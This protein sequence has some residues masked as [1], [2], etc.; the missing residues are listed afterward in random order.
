MK[1]EET[2]SLYFGARSSD[3]PVSGSLNIIGVEYDGAASFRKGA[4]QGPEAIRL[5]SDQL[6]SYSP[7]LD[8]DLG[9][10]PSYYDLG[11]LSLT[12]GG[13]ADQEYKA[14]RDSFA[15]LAGELDLQQ[16]KIRFLALGGDHSIAYPFIKKYLQ[17]YPYLLLIHLDAHAD[18]RDGFEGNFYSHASTMR[19]CLDHFGPRHQLVQFGIRSGTREEFSWMRKEKTLVTDYRQ[20]I[21]YLQE[22]PKGQPIYLTIDLDFFDPAVLPGTGTPEAGGQDFISFMEILISLRDKNL[23]GADVVELS[24]GID[25]TGNSAIFAAKVVR[26]LI[27]TFHGHPDGRCYYAKD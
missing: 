18:L 15:E 26:E 13:P 23:V 19:R 12:H 4:A 9:E 5:V 24:P 11:N 16:E 7:Y 27:L 3:K 25:P 8:L 21:T 22:L 20:F 14:I 10:T 17:T 6:E 2:T 1:S